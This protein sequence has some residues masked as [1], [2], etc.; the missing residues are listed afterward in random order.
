MP[1]KRILPDDITEKDIAITRQAK[2]MAKN[3]IEKH[4]GILNGKGNGR[5]TAF[6][7]STR[8]AKDTV[9]VTIYDP[10]DLTAKIDTGIRIGIKSIYS[11]EARA[12]A[13][14]AHAKI[15][16]VDDKIVSSEAELDEAFLEQT[17][18]ATAYWRNEGE[19]DPLFQNALNIE[20][21]PL[22]CTPENVRAL[23]TDPKTNW[24]QRQAQ[25]AYLNLAGFFE[26]PKTA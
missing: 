23:Y 15:Q 10:F 7:L 14:A 18:G 25:A 11:R 9:E 3:I 13:Q 24:I 8:Y 6:D 26:T 5:R 4:P 22:E 21:A 2:Q 12:A 16:I 20:G 1:R 17:I 19:T